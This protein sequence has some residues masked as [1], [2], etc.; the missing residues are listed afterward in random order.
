MAGPA[1]AQRQDRAG[2]GIGLALAAWFLFSLVDTSVKW[3][4]LSGLAAIQLA[5]MRYFVAFVLSL[6]SG[7]SSGRLFQPVAK[8]DLLLV[9]FRGSL[10][11]LATALNFFA[12][13]F[14]PLSVTSTILNAAPILVV[15]LAVPMLGERVGPWRIAA[16]IIGFIGVLTVIRPFGE[17]FHWASLLMV[18]NAFCVALFAILTRKLSGRIAPETMQLHMS[19]LGTAVLFIPAVL[20]WT[21]PQSPLAWVLLLGIGAAA[22]AGHELYSRAHLFAETNVLSP[23]GYSFIIYL[24]LTGFVVF[25]TVPDGATLIG[26]AIIVGSGLL[27][28]WREGKRKSNE[29]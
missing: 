20:S 8:S 6:L 22:W 25:G 18:I 23:F 3:L 11:V 4:V 27:I 1:I 28:W 9:A 16:V 7:A 26:A 13:N 14:L 12:L 15:V 21:T 5:F 17:T 2:P 29:L 10:L 19:A 24:T